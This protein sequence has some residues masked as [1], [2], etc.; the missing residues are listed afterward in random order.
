MG[1]K[2][3]LNAANFMGAF[4]FAGL[5]G[6]VTNSSAVFFLAAAALLVAGWMAGDLR[7]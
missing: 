3:K 1:A 5:L 2:K 6:L 7:A 4:M